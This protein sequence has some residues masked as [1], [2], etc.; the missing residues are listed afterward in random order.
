MPTVPGPEPELAPEPGPEHA[1]QSTP[2]AANGPPS[3]LA[4]TR[5]TEPSA[6]VAEPWNVGRGSDVNSAAG[7]EVTSRA[8]ALLGA[9]APAA[10]PLTRL[11][12]RSVAP[13]P[14]L[15]CTCSPPRGAVAG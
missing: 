1:E 6:S 4:S 13:V 14:R 3:R 11:P 7:P 9:V 8:G 2:V 5:A 10:P 15:T 12:A